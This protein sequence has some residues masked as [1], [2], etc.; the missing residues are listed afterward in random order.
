MT[1]FAL[2]NRS[3]A[4]AVA[5]MTYL[6]ETAGNGV[7]VAR[8][9]PDVVTVTH[10]VAAHATLLVDTASDI[11]ATRVA[12]GPDAGHVLPGWN[13]RVAVLV[14]TP[15]AAARARVVAE[16]IIERR[17]SATGAWLAGSVSLA[18]R[19]RAAFRFAVSPDKRMSQAYLQ[20]L[21]PSSSKRVSV[22]LTSAGVTL[23]RY[24]LEPW[25]RITV[26]LTDLRHIRLRHIRAA[27]GPVTLDVHAQGGMV[28]AE[29]AVYT[30]AGYGSLRAG[31]IA[32]SVPTT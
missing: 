11:A 5:R 27:R 21:N 28:V 24:T 25:Q 4:P 14:D 17:A 16:R 9:R 12:A 32:L 31:I 22:T 23:G 1:Q 19:P 18:V 26:N 20:A 13:Q 7:R 8:A 15:H 6:I 10:T 29:E 30:G 3:P 2:V